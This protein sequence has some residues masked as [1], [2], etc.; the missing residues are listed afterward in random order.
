MIWLWRS[1][2]L[3]EAP[4]G[5]SE[6]YLLEISGNWR[7]A[8][9]SW[10]QIG[11]PWEQAL[12]LLG[13]DEAAQRTALAIFERLG[14]VPATVV[15]RRWLREHGARGLPRGPLARTRA[16]QQGLT[17]RQQEVLQLLA[18]GLRDVEIADRLSISRR[19]AE[20]HVAGVLMKFHAR[21]RAEA[22]H[23]AYELGALP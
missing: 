2:D 9:D 3:S 12:A 13:G 4:S 23:R 20:Q 22:V 15:S 7:A 14:A 16:N 1:G 8:A 21:T 11:C 5:I 18:V 17:N 6:P 10:E 19:T